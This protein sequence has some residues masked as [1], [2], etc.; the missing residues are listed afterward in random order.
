MSITDV[1][2][3]KQTWKSA[4]H[5]GYARAL[6]TEARRL[7]LFEGVV[8]FNN[9]DVDDT[10]QPGDKTTVGSVFK[11]LLHE[12]IIEPY[13]ETNPEKNIFGG[14]RRSSRACNNGHKNP[15]YSIAS[16]TKLETWLQ[17]HGGVPAGPQMELLG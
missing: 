10:H 17:R 1:V 6:L 5:N 2:I 9:D 13:Y 8:Y 4:E 15:L 12:E 16:M 11:L 3:H 14:R 7:R